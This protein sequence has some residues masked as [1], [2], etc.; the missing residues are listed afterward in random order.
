VRAFAEVD[1]DHS[2]AVREGGGTWHM[3]RSVG[4]SLAIACWRTEEATEE[5]REPSS[6][7]LWVDHECRA[8]RD[9]STSLRLIL[10]GDH[11]INQPELAKFV[12]L[13]GEQTT[14]VA[15]DLMNSCCVSSI[16]P[17]RSHDEG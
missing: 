10:T 3:I 7:T 16:S 14:F 8:R 1:V 12:G 15:G 11:A 4:L 9:G 6:R 2:R 17:F 13:L 5:Y